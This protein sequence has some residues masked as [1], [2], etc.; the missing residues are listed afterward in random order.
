MNKK[1]HWI[2][3]SLLAVLLYAILPNLLFWMI[4]KKLGLDRPVFNI[5]YLLV[6]VVFAIGW[7]VVAVVLLGIFLVGD[8]LV[9]TS[10]VYPFV[11]LQD[12]AYLLS[13]LPYAAS[14]WQIAAA[15][16]VLAV[17]VVLVIAYHYSR[18]VGQLAALVLFNIGLVAYG[19]TVYFGDE[20]L[21][22]E[23]WYRGPKEALI[24]SQT[25]FFYETRTAGFVASAN[26]SREPLQ[27]IGFHGASSLWIN[28]AQPLNK[29]LL[30]VV[31]ES[32]GVMKDPRI[33]AALLAP[34]RAEQARFDWMNVTQREG[35]VATVM[36][37]LR[38]L[39]GLHTENY[40]LK[41]VTK[42]FE[43]CFPWQLKNQGY[44]TAA[45]HGAAGVMYDRVYWYPRAGLDA[46]QFMETHSW[47]TRCYS[48]PGACDREIMGKYIAH[49]FEGDK[50][51]FVYWLTL[52]T[53]AI[54]DKRDIYQDKFDCPRYQL[55]E[56]SE[57]CRM[58]KLHAQ[59]FHQLAEVL[60]SPSMRGVEVLLVGDHY[61]RILDKDEKEANIEGEL[62]T[63]VHLRVK[64]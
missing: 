8:I 25:L 27:E 50:K 54:Y 55:K 48:F 15:G 11:R 31:V 20:K 35:A 44:N 10:F 43:K 36:A 62:V 56:G 49:A 18:K 3:S 16:V 17:I 22:V 58:T 14:V 63:Q 29:K 1:E 23:R 12:V 64:D 37:E 45:F 34:L 33:Q 40:N 38:E 4:S 47:E 39:C 7:R 5:D 32:W 6:G 52:N 46:V 2:K 59:F 60:A 26:L 42:G 24:G 53:H 41:S 57:T 61:P 9:V 13:L 28:S 19:T 30:L 21:D 51:Q